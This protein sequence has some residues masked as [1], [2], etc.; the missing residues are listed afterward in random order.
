MFGSGGHSREQFTTHIIK[1]VSL[2]ETYI[3]E[4]QRVDLQDLAIPNPWK[5]KTQT[6]KIAACL[7]YLY[8]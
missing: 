3:V 1:T 4:E 6:R 8:Y 7:F 2:N 5:I